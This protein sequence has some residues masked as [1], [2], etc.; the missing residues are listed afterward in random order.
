MFSSAPV[1]PIAGDEHE[2]PDACS[3]ATPRACATDA[4]LAVADDGEALPV[5]VLA[6]A[7][8]LD[9]RAQVLGVVGERR[10]LRPAAALADAALVVAQD[11]ESAVGERVREL[12][13]NRD[14]EGGLVAVGWTGAADQD[15]QPAAVPSAVP[16][17]LESVPASEKPFAGMRTCSSPARVI[18]TRRADT[19][20][21]S[22]RTTSSVCAGTLTRSSRPDSSPQISTSSGRPGRRL[23]AHLRPPHLD[24]PR[25]RLDALGR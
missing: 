9:G 6:V 12:A 7:H 1:T 3:R 22:S 21:M 17:G 5:D 16:V 11:E 15:R 19:A 13:E 20:A 14:A 25:R 23:Q 2:R 18:V 24:Q 4:A 8:E 10:R